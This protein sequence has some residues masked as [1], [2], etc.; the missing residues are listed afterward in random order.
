[1]RERLQSLRKIAT[2][3]NVLALVLVVCG[4]VVAVTA[5]I[6]MTSENDEYDYTFG[7]YVSQAASLFGLYVVGAA[8]L[9]VGA[10]LVKGHLLP[11]YRDSD[12]ESEF[13]GG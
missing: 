9:F 1:M 3:M 12:S 5:I 6:G 8:I 11:F 10:A 7:D 13:R 2:M 4:T